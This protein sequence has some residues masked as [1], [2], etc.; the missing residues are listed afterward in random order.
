MPRQLVST[1]KCKSNTLY[2]GRK[3][4]YMS[5]LWTNNLI[6]S[7]YG[8]FF[9]SFNALNFAIWKEIR[10]KFSWN[11]SFLLFKFSMHLVCQENLLFDFMKYYHRFVAWSILLV[12]LF[13]FYCKLH[14]I[15]IQIF[16]VLHL[17]RVTTS[18]K[19]IPKDHL[20]R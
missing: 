10:S 15:L 16:Y 8:C 12:V 20:K 6:W 9:H 14:V 7:L 19:T 17:P 11:F 4:A 18:H 3:R 5:I 13:I 1:S 2:H